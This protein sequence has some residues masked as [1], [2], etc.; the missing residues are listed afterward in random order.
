MEYPLSGDIEYLRSPMRVNLPH[1]Q[2]PNKNLP[3]I[4]EE[5]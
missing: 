2:K 4:S 5:E 1:G 3:T